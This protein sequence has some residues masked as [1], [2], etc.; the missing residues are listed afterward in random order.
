VHELAGARDA[1]EVWGDFTD[2]VTR[3]RRLARLP[4][5]G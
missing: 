1:A 3:W 4:L 5:Q 2:D